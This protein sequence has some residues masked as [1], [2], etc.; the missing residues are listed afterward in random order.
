MTLGNEG[1]VCLTEASLE[2]LEGFYQSVL[3]CLENFGSKQNLLLTK[4]FQS[5]V[6]VG[7]I[8]IPFFATH[9]ALPLE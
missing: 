8:F 7:F 2:L 4:L 9:H 1:T 5:V 3:P 6:L